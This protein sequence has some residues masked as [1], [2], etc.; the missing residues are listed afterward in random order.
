MQLSGLA[1]LQRIQFTFKRSLYTSTH[2]TYSS[3]QIRIP[4]TT[5][6]AGSYHILSVHNSLSSYRFVF[7]VYT[8]QSKAAEYVSDIRGGS[9]AD[10]LSS[11]RLIN[12][13][14]MKTQ[15]GPAVEPQTFLSS[16]LD[17]NEMSNPSLSQSTP[18]ETVLDTHRA[19]HR[20][21]IGNQSRSGSG[22]T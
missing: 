8:G 11:L 12:Y 4:Y 9:L 21:L 10:G 5:Q 7:H 1:R 6:Q 22:V 3:E 16:P 18:G 14:V 13:H 15:K 19:H 17:V 2:E 20:R